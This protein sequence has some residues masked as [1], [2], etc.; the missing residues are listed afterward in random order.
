MHD[1]WAIAISRPCHL[2]LYVF[3]KVSLSPLYILLR[4]GNDWGPQ[5]QAAL[6]PHS[7]DQEHSAEGAISWAREQL[8]LAPA[9]KGGSTDNGSRYT[10]R[11]SGRKGNTNHIGTTV[12]GAAA[13]DD[14]SQPGDALR[15]DGRTTTPGF[16]VSIV[17]D[18]TQTGKNSASTAHTENRGQDGGEVSLEAEADSGQP[19]SVGWWEGGEIR[20]LVIPTLADAFIPD[21]D[22]PLSS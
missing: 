9:G 2:G 17:R 11:N 14:G 22:E 20:T 7:G 15:T 12:Q 10:S 8:K 16:D 1:R 13:V 5:Y 4:Q 6:F 19:P 21:H 18:G 3:S